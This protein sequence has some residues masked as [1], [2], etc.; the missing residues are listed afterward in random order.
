MDY[1]FKTRIYTES[2][3]FKDACLNLDSKKI[4]KLLNVLRLRSEDIVTVFNDKDGE[5]TGKLVLGSNKEG[6]ILCDSLLKE[7]SKEL[8]P[9]LIFSPI[10][11][12]RMEWLIEKAT[13]C[14][15][16]RIF[17]A[18]MGR[19]VVKNINHKKLINYCYSASEQSNRL[20]I[21]KLD[22]LRSLKEQIKF[23]I[24]F[25]KKILFCD[26]MLNSPILTNS[27]VK[28][29]PKN[30]TILI[31][32]EGGFKNDERKY[33]KGVTNTVACSLGSRVYR[34]ETAALVALTM[35]QMK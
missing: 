8:G 18:L 34:A 12:G 17:P 22:P 10:K 15:V 11:Y 13:E 31:G 6:H 16:E 20:S 27:L 33:L 32:P 29:D 3:L 2:S 35:A 30:V 24:D 5:W 14:G 1:K 7:G 4:H 28:I 9:W 26:E 19:T 25:N 21:P 23:S